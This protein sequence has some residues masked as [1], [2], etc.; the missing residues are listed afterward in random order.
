MQV[1]IKIEGLEKVQ[2][3]LRML[4]DRGIKEASAKAINDTAFQVK[5][6]MISEMNSV[7][8]QV[9]PY[10]KKSVWIEMATPDKLQATIL[11]TYYGG[12][13][14]DPQKI[15]AAQEA[16]G[17]RRDK[18]VEAALRRVGILPAGMQTV[19]PKDPFPGSDD[20]RGNF[21]GAF[22]VQLISYFQ[23]FREQ[24]HHANMKDKRKKK[25]ANVGTSAGGYKTINGF[26]YFIA[27]AQAMKGVFDHKER[28]LHLHPGI[29]AKQGIHGSTV[30]PVMMFT[31]SGRYKPRFSMERVAKVADVDSYLSKRMRYRIRQAAEAFQV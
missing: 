2:K 11:P 5:R 25:L 30:K 18:R 1:N 22:I 21:R 7:F 31:R 6:T 24:G 19:L 20:G 16:G 13:G 23:G 9:T 4:S 26:I 17:P 10:V 15:L 28:T 12:K 27:S 3:Q 8:N 29:W 14:I